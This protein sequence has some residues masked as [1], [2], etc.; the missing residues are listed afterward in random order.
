MV[1]PQKYIEAIN[2]IKNHTPKMMV[3]DITINFS[4][5]M[6]K[7]FVKDGQDIKAQINSNIDKFKV[8]KVFKGQIGGVID[9]KF[10]HVSYFRENGDVPVLDDIE[11]IDVD[12]YLEY[13]SNGLAI[14]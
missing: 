9:D 5:K 1:S 7:D 10:Y 6:K 13:V 12:E 4:E 2:T 3:F 8:T 11:F 14:K